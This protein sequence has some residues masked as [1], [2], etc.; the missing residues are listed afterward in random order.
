MQLGVRT[1]SPLLGI[2]LATA[3]PG[4]VVSKAKYDEAVLRADDEARQS[5][6]LKRQ[7]ADLQQR[8]DAM[9]AELQRLT[10]E[11]QQSQGELHKT[12]LDVDNREKT[13]AELSYEQQQREREQEAAEETID[14]LR[15]ELARVATHIAELSEQRDA[16]D[17]E[18][19]ALAEQL[20][21]DSAK[22]QQFEKGMRGRAL[23]VRDL[24]LAISGPLQKE[25]VR[26]D[27]RGERV[28][29]WTRSSTIFSRSSDKLT[30]DGKGLLGNMGK[31]LASTSDLIEVEERGP[32]EKS[33]LRS[34]R[35]RVVGEAL[36]K[37]GVDLGRV[38]LELPKAQEQA[39]QDDSKGKS[40]QLIFSIRPAPER[41]HALADVGAQASAT[42]Q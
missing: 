28:L 21:Q 31:A 10:A 3:A 29:V 2:V 22:L 30:N 38:H 19:N 7:L 35:L 17:E 33:G 11:W 39:D 34:K 18:K 12:Q 32:V 25:I 8:S 36:T 27:M 40:P 1:L 16:L 9:S 23:V 37:A 20:E 14:Q 15:K 41:E 5:A 4:C 26:L 24:T 6:E 13:L 42:V